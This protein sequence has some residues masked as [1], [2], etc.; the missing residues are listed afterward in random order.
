MK[1]NIILKVATYI[2]ILLEVHKTTK[3]QNY[4][5]KLMVRNIQGNFLGN[6]FLVIAL[7]AHIKKN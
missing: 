3:P 1:T 2:I 7:Y 6:L 5:I 4:S